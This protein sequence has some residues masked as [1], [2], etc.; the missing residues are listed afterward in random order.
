MANP[1]QGLLPFGSHIEVYKISGGNLTL[2]QV[3]PM[4]LV[5]G[6]SGIAVS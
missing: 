3:T 1:T 4:A 5:P 2:V 6:L